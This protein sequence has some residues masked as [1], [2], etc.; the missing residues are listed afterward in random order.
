MP[1]KNKLKLLNQEPVTTTIETLSHDGRGITH[2]NGKTIFVAGGLPGETLQFEYLRQRGRFDEARAVNIIT[3]KPG[4]VVP[5]C[6]HFGVCGGCSLQ[7]IDLS[8]QLQYKQQA[9]QELLWKQARIEPKEWLEPITGPGWGYRRKARLG[10]KYVAKKNRVL[11]GFRE[12]QGRLITDCQQCEVLAPAIG[13]RL[14]A[15]AALLGEFSNRDKIPQLEISAAD[16][17]NAVVIRHLAPFNAADL[18]ALET[19]AQQHDWRIYLQPHGIDSVKLF[20]PPIGVPAEGNSP[21]PMGVEG[22]ESFAP[23][24]SFRAIGSADAQDINRKPLP[25]YSA[26]MA[27]PLTGDDDLYYRLP[28]YN[29]RMEFQPLQFIQIN[30]EV[31]R[32]MVDRA[33]ELLDCQPQDRILDLFCG[34]GNFSLP[35][36]RLGATVVGVEGDENTVHQARHNAKINNLAQNQFYCANLSEA[37]FTQD[38]AQQP[39]DKMLLDPPRSGAQTI[40]AAMAQWRPR[41]LVYVSCDIATL[42]RDSQ[43][44]LLQGYTLTKAGLMDMFPHTQH[45][46]AIALFEAL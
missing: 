21:Y 30:A 4:R 43:L 46:E 13:Q 25:L 17:A 38:W 9:F 2:L 34:I 11:I 45:A 20:Y 3:A 28:R 6:A 35:M 32:A 24:P 15:F 26:G 29:L 19:F 22:G 7:H 1:R 37:G 5:K 44:M 39:F 8:L 33:L 10:V 14:N 36:G 40:I 18:T 31:N 41:R 16:N 23:P 27:D 42:A 12:K